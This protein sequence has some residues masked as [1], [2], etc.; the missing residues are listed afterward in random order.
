MPKVNELHWTLFLA[1]NCLASSST[2]RLILCFACYN[3]KFHNNF[4]NFCFPSRYLESVTKFA[5]YLFTPGF[6]NS[7][8]KH[9]FQ[10]WQRSGPRG[11]WLLRE[12]PRVITR[13][14]QDSPSAKCFWITGWEG[15][16]M[17]NWRFRPFKMLILKQFFQS[18]ILNLPPF[19][20]FLHGKKGWACCFTDSHIAGQI[21]LKMHYTI[22]VQVFLLSVL[23]GLDWFVWLFFF[24]F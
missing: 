8:T 21:H 6:S 17:I 12:S 10:S 23:A 16:I 19:F 5:F 3:E 18:I 24:F 13:I 11:A 9:H 20:H 4:W 7:Y 22:S 2:G 15:L 1:E 14:W